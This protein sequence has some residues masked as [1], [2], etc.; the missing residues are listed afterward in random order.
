VT[1]R[2]ALN[3]GRKKL[4]ALND[5][6]N[7]FLESEILLRYALNLTRAQLYLDLD[8]EISLEGE[9]VYREWIERRGQGEPAA[10]IIQVREFY[11]LDLYVDSRV[12]IPRP[13]TELLVETAL[14]IVRDHG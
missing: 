2:Q 7:P 4:A 14:A 8:R 1:L 9:K 5:I 13:E 3:L 11:G 12:L 10:Y 6:E